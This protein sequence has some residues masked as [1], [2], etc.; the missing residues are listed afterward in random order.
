MNCE[1]L[2]PCGSFETLE[3]AVRS[4]ADAVYLGAGDFN[5]RRNARNFDGEELERA[6]VFCAQHAV[7]LYLTLNT[8]LHDS[9]LPAALAL[10][11]KANRFGVDALIVQDPGLA[12]LLRERCPELPLHASTQMTVHD[13]NGVHQLARMGFCRVVPSRELSL[14][15][16]R[17]V[18]QAA[19]EHNM[20]TEVFV[21]G[22]LCMSFSGQ[23]Y[24]SAL[25]GCRSG[26]RG[27]CAQPCRLAFQ[28]EGSTGYDL[29][30]K[31]LS[32]FEHVP[33]LMQLGVT[34]LKIE[35]RRKGPEYVAAAVTAARQ[36]RDNGTVDGQ[37]AQALRSVF[38]RS[39]FTDGY[40]TAK[41]GSEM[42][43]VRTEE[44][45]ALSKEV[46]N[47]LH[48]L[49]RREFPRIPVSFE[50]SCKVGEYPQLRA[51][52]AGH[53]V[54]VTSSRP[55]EAAITRP[56]DSDSA[57]EQLARC[58]ATPYFLDDFHYIGDTN[59]ALP[60]SAL[61]ALRREVLDELTK[62]LATVDE[63][64]WKKLPLCP[65]TES[66]SQEKQTLRVR[67]L[68]QLPQSLDGISRA[69]LPASAEDALFDRLLT[70]IG[71]VGV[72]LPRFL[73]KDCT[74][75]LQRLQQL[76]ERGV[77][78]ALCEHHG[79]AALAQRA[80]LRIDGGMFSHVLNSASAQALAKLDYESVVLSF[81][82]TLEEATKLSSPI[83]KGLV[84]Y[85]YLPLML[86]RNCP[87]KNGRSCA[88]CKGGWLTDRKGI[89][90]F[91]RC[92]DSVSE[93]FNSRPLDPLDRRREVAVFDFL[94]LYFT[95]EDPDTI[96][97]I[98]NAA[99]QNTAWTHEQEFTRGLYYRGVL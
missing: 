99:V 25:L 23:C 56:L 26:N 79:A 5:A 39:G 21:H 36:A 95:H 27:L 32:Y 62:K 2:A 89:R 8:L 3:A 51:Q 86:T 80:G 63:R 76:R 4:G 84:A 69:Y 60:V 19:A 41:R 45:V 30:L 81:E 82:N 91:V 77:K 13:A 58:G 65:A 49:Y 88:G 70:E 35:G 40:L 75:L 85:G 38:S 18:C 28:A 31:D 47:S 12:M 17:A 67:F 9:E 46:K 74:A 54:C 57:H 64:E 92:R 73:S 11:E 15:E 1:I 61:N 44:D 10:A 52:A 48:E 72:E 66:P 42:F 94:L 20:E 90:F 24:L 96:Q 93:L 83:A 29:S 22:A 14:E 33:T 98:L 68:E 78:F 71:E 53:S 59:V 43:G 55:A 6:A 97:K 37:T 7:K 16:L 50:L 34:S 87:L